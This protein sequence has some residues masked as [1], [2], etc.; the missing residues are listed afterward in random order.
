[1]LEAHASDAE[2][3]GPDT[4][5]AT[6]AL[7]SEEQAEDTA[8]AAGRGERAFN[9][10][11]NPYVL[12]ATGGPQGIVSRLSKRQKVAAGIVGVLM[13][14]GGTFGLGRSSDTTSAERTMPAVQTDSQ[15]QADSPSETNGQTGPTIIDRSAESAVESE[16][17]YYL[18]TEL[19]VPTSGTPQV[20]ARQLYD[21]LEY[22]AINNEPRALEYHLA[23]NSG[24]LHEDLLSNIE[25]EAIYRDGGPPQYIPHPD[26]R[27]DLKVTVLEPNTFQGSGLERKMT[28][29][30]HTT[31]TLDAYGTTREYLEYK[32]ITVMP[33]DRYEVD[34]Q[35]NVK[36][37]TAWLIS[38]LKNE[39][40]PA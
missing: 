1:M 40:P 35:G 5:P 25:N 10:A 22:A 16:Q 39:A 33:V 15:P 36:P 18:P 12:A 13:L 24:S 9:V 11:A 7:T 28:I 21:V 37:V 17:S 14:L 31:Q 29:E 19:E 38:A 6:D 32:T 20:L 3:E 4:N 8:P 27:S 23:D 30:L 26:Y 2:T 34:R